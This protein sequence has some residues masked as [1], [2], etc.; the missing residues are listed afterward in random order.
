M[1]KKAKTVKKKPVKSTGKASVPDVWN[2][3]KFP[4]VSVRERRNQLL[5]KGDSN[6]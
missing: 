2:N 5:K 3:K 1:A 6:G 4:F